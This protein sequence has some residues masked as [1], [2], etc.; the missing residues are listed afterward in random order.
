MILKK[1]EKDYNIIGNELKINLWIK[2]LRILK[3]II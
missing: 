2:N 3:I 1:N